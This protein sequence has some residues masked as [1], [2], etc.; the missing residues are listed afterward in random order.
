MNKKIVV[1]EDNADFRE[2]L[3]E[4]L[5]GRGYDVF[6]AESGFDTAGYMIK[7]PVDLMITDIMLPDINGDEVCR[8]FTEKSVLGNVP[9]IIISSLDEQELREKAAK[10]KAAAYMRKPIDFDMLFKIINDILE[11]GI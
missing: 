9:V 10:M 4:R 7:N 1:L 6:S 5:K 3:V 2:I 8:L 11:P